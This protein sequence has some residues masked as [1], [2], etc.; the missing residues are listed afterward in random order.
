MEI[1]KNNNNLSQLP[2]KQKRNL[3]NMLINSMVRNF[4]DLEETKLLEN[5][6]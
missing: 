4:E 5:S 6:N 1:E 2:M 3:I